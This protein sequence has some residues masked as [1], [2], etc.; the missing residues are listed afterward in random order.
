MYFLIEE[1][2]D[3]LKPRVGP[4]TRCGTIPTSV[5]NMTGSLSCV[6]VLVYGMVG[7]PAAAICRYVYTIN[8]YLV[9]LRELLSS[10]VD[11][12]RA[13]R[14]YLSMILSEMCSER[15]MWNHRN[16]FSLQYDRLC[17]SCA[18]CFVI[19][20]RYNWREIL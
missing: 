4:N 8:M 3:Y 2:R 20:V 5:F 6:R 10:S 12:R 15:T 19:Y 18:C 11:R 17:V 16:L 14:G 1:P 7:A 9:A 13:S